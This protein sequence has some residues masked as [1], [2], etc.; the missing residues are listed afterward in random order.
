MADITQI[1]EDT[2]LDGVEYQPRPGLKYEVAAGVWGSMR[3]PTAALV[4][5]AVE[6][7]RAEDATDMKVARIILDIDTEFKDDEA[8]FGVY[9]RAVSDF[10]IML[11]RLVGAPSNAS[12]PSA[13]SAPSPQEGGSQ[14][15]P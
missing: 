1:N 12:S 3:R 14:V 15:A 4:D 9:S 11:T 2:L 13:P 10:F 5:M 8:I 6:A 7:S